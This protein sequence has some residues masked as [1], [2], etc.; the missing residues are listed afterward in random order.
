MSLDPL[1]RYL[2]RQLEDQLTA[3]SLRVEKKYRIADPAAM[4]QKLS[5][6]GARKTRSG[7]EHNE[8]FDVNGT[9]K[10]K[11]HIAQAPAARR[12]QHLADA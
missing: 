9:L 12:R 2:A 3:D 4:R 7:Y 8:L 11:R 5:R 10:K 6:L 1:E